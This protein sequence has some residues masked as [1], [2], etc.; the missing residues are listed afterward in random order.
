MLQDYK[1]KCWEHLGKSP[2]LQL[3]VVSSASL[4]K[5]Q[6]ITINALGLYGN[7]TSEREKDC[8]GSGNDGFTYFGS[9]LHVPENSND[10][11]P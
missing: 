1:Q 3:E 11:Q 7:F 6:I 8:P 4:P 2:N 5:G 9:I 10:G